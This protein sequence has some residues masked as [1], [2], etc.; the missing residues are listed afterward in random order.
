[1]SLLRARN[2]VLASPVKVD[3]SDPTLVVVKCANDLVVVVQQNHLTL[4]STNCI[5]VHME[6]SAGQHIG[7]ADLCRDS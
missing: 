2:D 3:S 4:R 7:H 6:C 1:M 5:I